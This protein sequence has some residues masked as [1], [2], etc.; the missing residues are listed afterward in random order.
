MNVRDKRSQSQRT[1]SSFPKT[2]RKAPSLAQSDI[3]RHLNT[4][5]I[6]E[7]ERITTVIAC[8]PGRVFYRPGETGNVLFLLRTGRVQLYHLSIDGRKLIT[9]TLEAGACFGEMPLI[10]QGMHNSFAEAVEESRICVMSKHDVERL[11]VRKPAVTLALLQIVGQRLVQLEAQ[12]IDAT[13]KGTPARL[14]TLL[15]QLAHTDEKNNTLLVVDGL[16][17]E[18]LAERLGVY[19]E[20]VSAALRDLKEAGAI[21]LGRKHITICQPIVLQEIASS[22]GRSSHS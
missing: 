19:R 20:T 17:Q 4:E 21:E 6:Q 13:F 3:F 9:A 11:L 22:G 1:S 18:E 12:L 8:P 14:A 15:L 7:L 10:G 16:S 5:E 2:E